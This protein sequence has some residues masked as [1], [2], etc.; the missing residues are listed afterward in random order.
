MPGVKVRVT[1]KCIGCGTCTKS[2]CFV[3]AISLVN[4]RSFI[5]ERCR[6]CGRCVDICPQKAIEL[7]IDTTYIEESIKSIEKVVDVV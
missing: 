1:N 4:K 3:N 6:G 7:I 5:S 2:V